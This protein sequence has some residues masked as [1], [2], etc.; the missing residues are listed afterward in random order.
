MTKT[1]TSVVLALLLWP[2]SAPRAQD[3]EATAPDPENL[4][5]LHV[6]CFSIPR[7]SLP[8]SEPEL[9]F[10]SVADPAFPVSITQLHLPKGQATFRFPAG[11]LAK[12]LEV[13]DIHSF[14]FTRFEAQ[15]GK[16]F[17]HN[18]ELIGWQYSLS[19]YRWSKDDYEFEIRGV[20]SEF[21]AVRTV[22]RQDQ[23]RVIRIRRKNDFVYFALTPY[24]A[25][26]SLW[27]RGPSVWWRR[28]KEVAPAYPEELRKA[29]MSGTVRI[30]GAVGP[31]GE[32]DI[33]RSVLVESPHVGFAKSALAAVKNWRFAYGGPGAASDAI[34]LLTVNFVLR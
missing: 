26:P 23:T 11:F 34:L 25:S 33:G 8:D 17:Q 31:G 12:G 30:F 21:P 10:T 2:Q 16:P 9:R 7:K 13:I 6:V 14:F 15:S 20:D 3:V 4:R 32:I 29:H 1:L 27:K 24:S 18:N 5:A 22:G 19:L 28:V